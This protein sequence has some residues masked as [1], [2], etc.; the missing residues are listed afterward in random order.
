MISRGTFPTRLDRRLS[1]ILCASA[2]LLVS[3]PGCSPES[4]GSTWAGTETDSAGITIVRNPAEGVWSGDDG[5]VVEEDLR[6]GSLAGGAEY[7]F[8]QVGTIAV[9]STG[10]I[11]VSDRQNRLVSVFGADGTFVRS[12]GRP[13]SGPGEFGR[14]IVDVLLTHSDTLLVPDVQ[15]RRI[16][17]FGPDGT[18]LTS[19]A[20]HLGEERPLRFNWNAATRSITV[21]LR[22]AP[23][24]SGSAASSMDA[25]RVV[26][27]SGAFGDTLL[28]VPSGRLFGG[29]GL[30]YFTP[31]PMWDVTDSLTVVYAVNDEYRVAFHGQDGSIR[32]IVTKAHE[33]RPIAD[34]DIRAFFAYL[35]QA[36]I[37]AGATPARLQQN[38]R[39]VSFADFFPAF[40]R[41]DLGYQ[42]SLWVQPV[43]SPADLSD[44]DIERYNFIEDFGA[45]GW[46][47]FDGD[48][49]YL[50]VV[51]MPPRFQ[52]RL[53]Y[54]DQIYGVAR[55][56]LDVQYVVRLRITERS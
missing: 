51:E 18:T 53:F 24:E 5:W 48:G 13:G 52:P 30:Q 20:L 41:F 4:P 47:V 3:T 44:E 38:H 15:N 23:S 35:D 2:V 39:R 11:V 8:G 32:R 28:V 45:S 9:T 27:S 49:H 40:S 46:D 33:P 56:E 25:I 21:Q 22:P 54:G 55:D 29:S 17:R 31:E 37:A 6:I 36:W 1:Q 42:G 50:G 12:V 7:Q 26:E 34:R 14:A 16:N 10:E 19:S 43:R